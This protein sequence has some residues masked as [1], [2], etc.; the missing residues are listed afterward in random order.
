MLN[1]AAFY[2]V[3]DGWK[4]GVYES[5]KECQSQIMDYDDPKYLK[6]NSLAEA[7]QAFRKGMPAF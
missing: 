6:Y 5:W 2:V 1:T 4:P 3:F 7:K